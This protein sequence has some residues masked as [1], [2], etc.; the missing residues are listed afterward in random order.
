MEEKVIDL[1]V[2]T[3]QGLRNPL[4]IY[5]TMKEKGYVI[6]LKKVKEILDNLAERQINKGRVKLKLYRI[7][8][9]IGHYQCDLMFYDQHKVLNRGYHIILSMIEIPTRIGYMEPLKNKQGSSIV[10]AFENIFKRIVNKPVNIVMDKGSEFID[11]RVQK[12]LKDRD[13]S[14]D[15]ADTDDKHKMG[16]IE[17]FNRTIRGYFQKYFTLRNTFKW[18]DVIEDIEYN[19]NHTV[20][21]TLRKA[22]I[23]M[24]DNDIEKKRLEDM[25]HNETV[26]DKID[27]EEGDHVRIK[28]KKTIY[29][30]EGNQYTEEVY[31]IEA[32]KGN[33]Y[34]VKS[35]YRSANNLLKVDVA[36]LKEVKKEVFDKQKHLKSEKQKRV[37]KRLKLDTKNIVEGKR[38]RKPKKYDDYE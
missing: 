6:T 13:I 29:E 26:R 27:L 15:Y 19:Y 23:E 7:T 11:A 28:N 38:T 1:Y 18:I 24:T 33:R 5:K 31:V 3:K 17:R 32:V 35:R 14:Y 2:D 37:F 16:M 34:L 36:N 22:P 12:F 8:A 25:L 9:P 10:Q 20:H 30:K 4:L 21:S